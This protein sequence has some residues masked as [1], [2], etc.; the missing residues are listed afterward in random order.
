MKHRL[1]GCQATGIVPSELPCVYI[2]KLTHSSSP[3]RPVVQQLRVLAPAPGPGC[4][5][6]GRQ[7]PG[8]DHDVDSSLHISTEDPCLAEEKASEVT[9]FSPPSMDLPFKSGCGSRIRD[10]LIRYRPDRAAGPTV[11]S[12]QEE[13]L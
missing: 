10:C 13:V 8:G 2:S 3:D 4:G 7:G 12:M 1:H 11:V 5:E 9:P 6:L